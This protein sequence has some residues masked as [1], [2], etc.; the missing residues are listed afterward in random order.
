MRAVPLIFHVGRH[1]IALFDK[2]RLTGFDRHAVDD[3]IDS[4]FIWR[5]P[6]ARSPEEKLEGRGPLFWRRSN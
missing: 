6:R 2:D 1:F 5:A 3:Q 4:Y